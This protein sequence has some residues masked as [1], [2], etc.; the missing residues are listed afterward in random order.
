M[1]ED[2]EIR[3]LILKTL[4]L[5]EFTDSDQRNLDELRK[6]EEIESPRFHNLVDRMS[7][8]D[9][10]QEW[11]LGYNYIIKPAGIIL[12]EEEGIPPEELVAK[13]RRIRTLILDLLAKVFEEKGGLADLP[14]SRIAEQIEFS[15][16]EVADNLQLMD[17]LGYVEHVA[18]STFKITFYGLES[19]EEWLEKV[20]IGDEFEEIS[21]LKP[22]LRGVRF[23][24]LVSRVLSR[25]GWISDESVRTEHEEMDIIF[26]KSRE[27]YLVECKWEKDPIEARIVRELFGKLSNRVGVRGVLFSMSGFTSG[28]ISQ[29]EEYA[30]QE[31][32]LFF[33]P[34]DV[35]SLIMEGQEFDELLN[36]KYKSYVS[37]TKVKFS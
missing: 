5:Y 31:I 16:R 15:E 28:A 37:L 34:E 36:T 3:Q 8:E 4:Y 25:D 2:P 18:A 14:I 12:A 9:L 13:N 29:A 6:N 7:H 24:S 19:V 11:T 21:D 27:Y 17:E 32:V 23:Q 1:N 30:S 26:S 20:S 22:Q 35:S 10:I 33:G